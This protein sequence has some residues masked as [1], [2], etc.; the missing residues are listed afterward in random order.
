[1]QPRHAP[2]SIDRPT[3]KVIDAHSIVTRDD[4]ARLAQ[5][6]SV[7]SV[8]WVAADTVLF[9]D[10]FNTLPKIILIEQSGLRRCEF[11][12][13]GG[14]VILAVWIETVDVKPRVVSLRGRLILGCLGIHPILGLLMILASQS[15]TS[16]TCD[17]GGP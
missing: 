5:H 7:I 4:A 2:E 15:L 1:L 9:K 10:W 14:D 11:T 16:L 6:S 12:E 8:S 17:W 3:I 13:H